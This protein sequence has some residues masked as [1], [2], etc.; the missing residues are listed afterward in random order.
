M[1]DHFLCNLLSPDNTCAA[2]TAEDLTLCYLCHCQPVVNRSLHPFRHRNRSDVPSLTDKD[3]NGPMV[4]SA[5]DMIKGQINEFFSTE[6]TS[7]E[8][9]KDG[10][11]PFTLRCP[12]WEVATGS[13]F[14]HGQPISESHPQFL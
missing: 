4:F 2:N 12:D 5:L 11:I 1:P 13:G 8:Y 3:N 10:S 7:Q 6:T 14:V 9:R